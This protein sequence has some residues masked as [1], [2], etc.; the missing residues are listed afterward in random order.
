MR[1]R[2]LSALLIAILL[3]LAACGGPGAPATV[4]G[5]SISVTDALGRTVFL[6]QPP[7][8][9]VTA[10]RGVPL[11]N[12]ALYL[13]PQA[14]QRVAA[15]GR[16][17]QDV[18]AFLG[19]MDPALEQKLLL[20][21]EAGVEQIAPLHP[22][23]VVLKSNAPAALGTSLE[24]LGIP[25][26]YLDL[27]TPEQYLRDIAT[28]GQLFGDEA[29]AGELQAYYRAQMERV[30]RATAGLVEKPRVLVLQHS[31]AAGTAWSVPPESWLQTVLVEMAGGTAVWKGAF[32]GGGWA[33]VNMEQ[34]AAWDADCILVVQYDG[35][36]EVTVAGLSGDPQWQA[37]RAVRA[38]RIYAWPRDHV[39][40]D[41]P[42]PR[43][44]LG[45]LWTAGRLHP[46][47]LAVDMTAEVV[48]FYG[49]L[50]GMDEVTVRSH[51]LP[52]LRG[53]LP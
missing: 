31:A 51:I 40:W 6:A 10:G 19:L 39:S 15:L 53:S 13:F 35:D 28:L 38:G 49:Q 11:L 22:D 23:V 3:P 5:G 14:R 44:I 30:A 20:E 4:T 50:Y 45:L 32:P 26:V 47:R 1:R 46:E 37:L 42:D 25:V 41:Q 17:N 12:D 8:R 36:A 2:L 27:E 9:I 18:A 33:T 52:H 34:I 29:R 16:S 43:W 21:R 24:Q 48:R 7:Q